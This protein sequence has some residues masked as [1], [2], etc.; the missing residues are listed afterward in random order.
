MK[1]VTQMPHVTT[2][3]VSPSNP[4]NADDGALNLKSEERRDSRLNYLQDTNIRD[5]R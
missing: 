1:T 2:L 4:R 3:I 5:C